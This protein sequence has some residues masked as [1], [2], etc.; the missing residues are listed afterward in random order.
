MFNVLSAIMLAGSL[1]YRGYSVQK[2]WKY[3]YKRLSIYNRRCKYSRFFFPLTYFL[4]LYFL[5][6][7]IPWINLYFAHDN[8]FSFII[9]SFKARSGIFVP[10]KPGLIILINYTNFSIETFVLNNKVYFLQFR[11]CLLRLALYGLHLFVY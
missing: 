6:V 11:T 5:K 3:I 1:I 9:E 8:L 7:S 4:I 10:I 2:I